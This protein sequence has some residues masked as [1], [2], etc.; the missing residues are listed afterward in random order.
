[1]SIKDRL[2]GSIE[3]EKFGGASLSKAE[4]DHN[5]GISAAIRCIKESD[6]LARLESATKLTFVIVNEKVPMADP[7]IMCGYW[8]ESWY[9]LYLI[10]KDGSG[11]YLGVFPRDL[12]KAK[13]YAQDFVD[14]FNLTYEII[15]CDDNNG[16]TKNR[17]II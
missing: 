9:K 17:C 2:I 7:K 6:E 3:M 13:K 5:A 15:E 11:Y 1:M 14:S 8:I 4:R 16:K 12:E 10:R